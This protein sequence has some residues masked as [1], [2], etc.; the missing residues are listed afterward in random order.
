MR[1]YPKVKVTGNFKNKV[2]N[3]RLSRARQ[4]VE[5]AFGI[6]SARFRVF[7]RPFECK[8][9]TIDKVVLATTVLHNYLRSKKLIEINPSEED[10]EL[11]CSSLESIFVD[12]PQNR[13]RSSRAAF[14][15]REQFKDCFNSPQGSVEWQQRAVERGQY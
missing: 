11:A 5:C 1:P 3:Y 14:L 6:L 15:I 13:A 7:K 12:L 4:C 9:E 2:F 10:N 8:L